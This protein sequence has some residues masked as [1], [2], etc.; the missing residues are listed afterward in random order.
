MKRIYL[1]SNDVRT[2]EMFEREGW[3]I[4][5]RLDDADAVC[6][7]GGADVS[8]F[9]YGERPLKETAF[10]GPRD[11][12]EIKIWKSVPKS[13]PKIGISRGAQFGNVMCGGKLW[14]HVDNHL[15]KHPIKDILNLSGSK[16]GLLMASSAHHQMCQL[17][18]EAL[19][20]ASSNRAQCK[21]SEDMVTWFGSVANKNEWEDPEAFYYDS[22]NFLGVQFHPEYQNSEACRKLF[23]NM[24][25]FCYG[26]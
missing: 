18:D 8:P 17:T 12:L 2:K 11:N 19:L 21:V 5:K 6:F 13:L 10:N 3:W 1:T 23:F 7:T 16:N 24:I 4:T 14:Q 25:E 22:H 26:D 20:L 9:L 15:S